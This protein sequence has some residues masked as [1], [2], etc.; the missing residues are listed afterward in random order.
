MIPRGLHGP[1]ERAAYAAACARAARAWT[2]AVALVGPALGAGAGVVLAADRSPDMAGGETLFQR[3]C[4]ACHGLAADGKGPL[5][6][7]L[8]LQPTDLTA[9]RAANGGEFPMARVIARIDGQDPLV[10][11]GSP[12][13]VFGPYL[14]SDERVD[15]TDPSGKTLEVAAPI[16]DLVAW[17]EGI[18]K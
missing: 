9:L 12:M 16:G 13:P 1:A 7:V 17:L 8:T 15:L 10:A 2:L 3:N 11:H 4:A 14:E 18:Q 6:P 5:A